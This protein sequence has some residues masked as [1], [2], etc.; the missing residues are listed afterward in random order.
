VHDGLVERPAERREVVAAAASAASGAGALLRR[1]RERRHLTQLDVAA[2]SAVSA[3]HLSFIENGRSRPSREMVLHLAQRLDIP[4]CDRNH[5]LLAAGYAPG[6][7][8]DSLDERDMAPVREIL[9]RLLRA[10]EP[11]PALVA[12]QHWNIVAANRGV[13]FIVRDVAPELLAPP[14]NALRIALHPKGLG[15][16]IGN[17]GEWSACLLARLRREMDVAPDSELTALYDELTDFPGVSPTGELER[18][19]TDGIMLTHTLEL[20]D[21][22][23]TL[24]STVT[25]F[26][27][28]RDLTL[29][30]L[31][32]ESFF[33][34]DIKTAAILARG[35]AEVAAAAARCSL[36]GAAPP[37][38][39]K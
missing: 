14:A 6:F 38:A 19:A 34:A 15:P 35:V 5:L 18:T 31:T 30:E 4:L 32:L 3:R 16:R 10:Q 28:A 25:T 13:D 12:D 29:A 1:W 26:G 23:L 8:G 9:E 21:A 27:T 17:F 33:P 24:F 37:S 7:S 39:G 22:K 36:A 20:E 11:Y 2:R